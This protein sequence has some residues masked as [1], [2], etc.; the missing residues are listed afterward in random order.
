MAQLYKEQLVVNKTA[1][2]WNTF[3]RSIGMFMGNC[4]KCLFFSSIR[5]S[6]AFFPANYNILEKTFIINL[7]P[8]ISSQGFLEK[9]GIAL[10][11]WRT[12][13]PVISH[14]RDETCNKGFLW[15]HRLLWHPVDRITVAKKYA[16][17][18]PK[19]WICFKS[20]APY[21]QSHRF[22]VGWLLLM[23]NLYLQPVIHL[24]HHKLILI[25]SLF[26]GGVNAALRCI[27]T[28][29]STSF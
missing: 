19:F 2:A 11:F 13:S 24:W 18:K 22:H 10:Q 8:G 20:F 6:K 14:D 15:N 1:C 23:N 7:P 25:P 4:V 17:F 28:L 3:R 29:L 16:L 12:F 21:F 27:H 26:S 9:L 5:K